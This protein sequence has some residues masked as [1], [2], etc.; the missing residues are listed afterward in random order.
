MKAPAAIPTASPV[1]APT[2][3]RRGSDGCSDEVVVA[4]A[5]QWGGGWKIPVNSVGSPIKTEP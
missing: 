5:R 3:F 1:G 4:P 2:R